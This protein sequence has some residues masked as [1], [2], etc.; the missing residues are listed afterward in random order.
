AQR[1]QIAMKDRQTAM[2]RKDYAQA[3]TQAEVA[4]ENK[5]ND[6]A[7]NKLRTDAQRQLDL[8]NTTKVQRY[9]TAMKDGQTALD[10]KDYAL[11]IT[12]SEERREGKENDPGAKKLRNKDKRQ[13]DLVN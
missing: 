10:R 11:A 7:A 1:Y 8:V 2:D 5:A 3:I 13:L 12:R 4:L 9:Q 6:P